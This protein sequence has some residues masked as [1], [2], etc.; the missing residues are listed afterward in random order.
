MRDH[1][2]LKSCLAFGCDRVRA[3]LAGKLI[4]VCL[5]AMGFFIS[6][7]ESGAVTPALTIQVNGAGEK[8]VFDVANNNMW[9]WNLNAFAGQTYGQQLG[10]IQQLNAAT[11]FDAANWHLASLQEMQQL[12]VFDSAT[13]RQS[14]HPSHERYDGGYQWHYWSGRYEVGSGGIHAMSE[15]AWGN[16]VWGPFDYAWGPN[17]G[18]ALSDGSG[19]QE[20]GAFVVASVPEP[21]AMTLFCFG[22]L[23]L[24]SLRRKKAFSKLI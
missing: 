18:G 23:A 19:Y 10:G 3:R 2:S 7:Y 17:S 12:W 13:I 1:N 21:G 22:G 6:S 24:N 20:R 16:F 15:T 8:V 11:Y 9:Y 4:A 14:F 5:A